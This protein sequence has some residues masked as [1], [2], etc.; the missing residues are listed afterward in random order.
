MFDIHCTENLTPRSSS[1]STLLAAVLVPILVVFLVVVP[2]VILVMRRRRRRAVRF[3]PDYGFVS[4]PP[5]EPYSVRRAS[6]DSVAT[7]RESQYDMCS[8]PSASMVHTD[9][10][11]R[12]GDPPSGSLQPRDPF[13]DTREDDVRSPLFVETNVPPAERETPSPAGSSHS[14]AGWRAF[15]PTSSIAD[16]LHRA[17]S[18]IGTLTSSHSGS[19][20]PS[21]TRTE[22]RADSRSSPFI[23]LHKSGGRASHSDDPF[24][25]ADWDHMDDPFANLGARSVDLDGESREDASKGPSRGNYSGLLQKIRNRS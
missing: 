8:V 25:D 16:S 18:R 13:R 14:R 9:L 2:C 11:P 3:M 19:R 20:S 1:S 24:A 10:L 4:N 21:D 7:T 23:L 15:S 22:S 6:N 12:E 5:D 17:R